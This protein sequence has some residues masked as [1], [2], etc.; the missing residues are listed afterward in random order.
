[1]KSLIKIS[2]V[3]A[4]AFGSLFQTSYASNPDSKI[5]KAMEESERAHWLSLEATYVLLDTDENKQFIK[6]N[7][8]I[9]KS[10]CAD[11][12]H[13]LLY[14]VDLERDEID[15]ETYYWIMRKLQDISKLNGKLSDNAKRFWILCRK[16][17][18]PL[19][20]PLIPNLKE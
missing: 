2:I 15:G 5:L 4:M 8:K 3:I 18:L 6:K 7:A 11:D 1:M 14:L 10:L 13:Y 12:V 19:W 17:F 16:K 20:I 9:L